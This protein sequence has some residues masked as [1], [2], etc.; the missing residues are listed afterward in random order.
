M[1]ESGRGLALLT[2]RGEK[3][4]GKKMDALD[5][6]AVGVLGFAGLLKLTGLTEYLGNT[7]FLGVSWKDWLGIAL[8]ITVLK[9]MERDA[10]QIVREEIERALSK[11][12]QHS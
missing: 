3:K 9:I 4:M 7:A 2:P 1:I 6:L 10:R 5:W 8:F 11:Y 12:R